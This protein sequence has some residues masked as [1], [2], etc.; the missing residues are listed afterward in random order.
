[1][2]QGLSEQEA[3]KALSEITAAQQ[4]LTQELVKQGEMSPAEAENLA[5]SP[6]MFNRLM[7]AYRFKQHLMEN[8]SALDEGLMGAGLGGLLL[9][10]G[11]LVANLARRNVP[12]AANSLRSLLGKSAT[13]GAL[14]GVAGGGIG[15]SYATPM[16][17]QGDL[18]NL[19]LLDILNGQVGDNGALRIGD[20][21]VP[22]GIASRYRHLYQ[23]R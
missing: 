10:G 19:T 11:Q 6:M 20:A 14:G 15:Y 18:P 1:M 16:S 2:L 8:S 21:Y 23:T 7:E 22:E 5:Q 4:A 9:G 12:G 13:H 3:P 17:V